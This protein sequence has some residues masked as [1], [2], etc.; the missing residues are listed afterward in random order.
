MPLNLPCFHDRISMLLLN[1]IPLAIYAA[2]LSAAK[3]E[4]LVHVHQLLP[5]ELILIEDV[6][7]EHFRCNTAGEVFYAFPV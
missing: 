4:L 1:T 3:Q 7:S 5:P 2:H 6:C